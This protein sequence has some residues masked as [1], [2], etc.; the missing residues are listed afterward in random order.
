[1][2][3]GIYFIDEYRTADDLAMKQREF[4][5]AMKHYA[6]QSVLESNKG[7]QDGND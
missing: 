5:K 2:T 4:E 1:M 7:G 6:E 3:E